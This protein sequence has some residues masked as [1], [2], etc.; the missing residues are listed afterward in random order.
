M[1]PTA[2]LIT[3]AVRIVGSLPVLRWPF[4][5]GVLAIL[6]DL[7]DLLLLGLLS[8]RFRV[9][10]YQVFDKYLDQVYMVAFLIVA[11]RWSGTERAIAVG[12]FAFRMVGFVLFEITGERLV[13]VAFPNVFELW[14]L[15]VAGLHAR[16]VAPAWTRTRVIAV[17]GVALLVK[18]VQEWAIH[19]ARLFDGIY[20]LDVV[21]DA[22]NWLTGG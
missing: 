13:L 21:R 5:G 3:G 6:V 22:W 2:V 8:P 20:A 9:E 17:L 18:E 1:D 7:S 14:F 12:L 19:G 11:L 16:D 10:E 15:V 4:A